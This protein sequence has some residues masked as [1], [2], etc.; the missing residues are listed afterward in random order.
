MSGDKQKA[1]NSI[2][3]W[4]EYHEVHCDGSRGDGIQNFFVCFSHNAQSKTCSWLPFWPISSCL[5]FSPER[6]SHKR[7]SPEKG[8]L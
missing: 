1:F 2:L 7:I 5:N 6:F 8:D 4:A 3:L